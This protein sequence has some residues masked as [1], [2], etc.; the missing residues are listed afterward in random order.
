M[1]WI[2]F[3][4]LKLLLITI[5]IYLVVLFIGG[6]IIMRYFFADSANEVK[7]IIKNGFYTYPV[8]DEINFTDLSISP[9][10]AIKSWE[11]GLGDGTLLAIKNPSHQYEYAQIFDVTL[12]VVSN[13]G[14]KH[15]TTIIAALEVFPNPIAEFSASTLTTSEL[16]SE[17]EFYNNSSGAIS[18]F[19]DFDNSITS[20]EENPIIDFKQANNYEVVLNVVS[21]EG[22]EDEM[23]ETVHI[24]LEYTL[25]APN[26]FSPNGDGNNDV[27]LAQGNGVKSFEM[28]VFDRWGGLVFKSS[29]IKYGWDGLDV[30][31]NL[32][33]EGTY[34]YN[35]SLYDHNE[36]L[37]IYNGDLKLMR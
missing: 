36:K 30:S 7:Y 17:I 19:W 1:N 12:E 37:W 27:F 3:K 2:K 21:A 14:C 26:S 6:E 33:A 28:Q 24:L 32:V 23:I 20:T 9:N 18:Y 25:Y 5:V 13:E 15:D 16:L 4:G 22:C 35:I 11:W 8:S 29:D 10:S 31:N 34:M